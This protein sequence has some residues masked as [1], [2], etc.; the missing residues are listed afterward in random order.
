MVLELL[1]RPELLQT[2]KPALCLPA[3]RVVH[4]LPQRRDLL[5]ENSRSAPPAPRVRFSPKSAAHRRAPPRGAGGCRRRISRHWFS[6]A[7]PPARSS[8]L[9][10]K[11]GLIHPKNLAPN[12]LPQILVLQE[13]LQSL[14]T[15]E[16]FSFL[17][18]S[19]AEAEGANT[20]TSFQRAF[21]RAV[22]ASVI[23]V[24]LPVPAAPRI[25][26]SRD[27]GSGE[28]APPPRF[29]P[30]SHARSDPGFPR[31]R[32]AQAARTS[33]GRPRPAQELPFLGQNFRGR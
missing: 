26:L 17:N 7:R 16:T 1:N 11:P 15:R 4:C 10:E 20:W 23:I 2:A 13:L 33:P 12:P 24:V 9:G 30:R 29:A 14:R 5:P 27:H 18:T 19:T 22:T 6:R 8:A 21:S 28:R 32:S 31:L 3:A 25:E